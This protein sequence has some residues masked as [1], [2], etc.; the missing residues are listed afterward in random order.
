MLIFGYV[1]MDWNEMEVSQHGVF[2][3]DTLT[4][5]VPLTTFLFWYKQT[6]WSLVLRVAVTSGDLQSVRNL[7]NDS[8]GESVNQLDQV[9]SPQRN[10]SRSKCI[11]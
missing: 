7:L 1:G 10:L 3:R 9:H 5:V 11:T 2:D 6:P 4:T 8:S